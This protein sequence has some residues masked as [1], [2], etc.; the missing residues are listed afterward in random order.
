MIIQSSKKLSKCSKQELLLIIQAEVENR[1]KLINLIDKEYD[2]WN[3][4]I[5][6]GRFPNYQSSERK[7]FLD[8][9]EAATNIVKNFWG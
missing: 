1:Q 5:E 3:K 8:G 2:N 7:V 4:N 6:D 9:I